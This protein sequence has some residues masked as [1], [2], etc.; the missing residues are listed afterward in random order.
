MG[1]AIQGQQ[2]RSWGHGNVLPLLMSVSDP[3]FDIVL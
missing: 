1:V 2:E 3:G